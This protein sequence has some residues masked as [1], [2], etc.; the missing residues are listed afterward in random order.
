MDYFPGR[1]GNLRFLNDVQRLPI[2]SFVVRV[3]FFLLLA[4][5]LIL[6][7]GRD[8]DLALYHFWY[9]ECPWISAVLTE[10]L[11]KYT[12]KKDKLKSMNMFDQFLS[13]I[14]HT[15]SLSSRRWPANFGFCSVFVVSIHLLKSFFLIFQWSSTLDFLLI[16]KRK[17]NKYKRRVQNMPFL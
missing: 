2:F 12:W 11:C 13:S 14:S 5:R 7:K 9:H 4:F 16:V 1:N 3:I 10:R 6:K 8:E 15:A 17:S